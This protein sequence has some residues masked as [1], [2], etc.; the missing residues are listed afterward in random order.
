MSEPSPSADR[1]RPEKNAVFLAPSRSPQSSVVLFDLFANVAQ[2][3]RRLTQRGWIDAR[4]NARMP[5]SLPLFELVE[6][7]HPVIGKADE[8]RFAVMRVT[9]RFDA[10]LARKQLDQP[11]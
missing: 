4:H 5:V 2:Q 1:V 8:I 6:S 11:S 3:R 7:F 9:H 10:S